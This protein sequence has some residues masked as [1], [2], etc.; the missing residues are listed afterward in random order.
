M[1]S[2]A[3]AHLLFLRARA[4]LALSALVIGCSSGGGTSDTP[5]VVDGGDDASTG[6]T[7]SAPEVGDDA[8][9]A[10]ASDVADT[11][12][13]SDTGPAGCK[14]NADCASDPK[15]KFCLV[16][17]AGPGVCVPCL[18]GSADECPT[19]TYCAS[20]NTCETGCKTAADCTTA[21]SDAGA[22]EAGAD[23]AGDGGGAK[24]TCNTTTHRCV[25]CTDDADCPLGSVCDATSNACVPG[26]NPKH[27]CAPGK[28]CCGTTC[29]DTQK[30]PNNCGGCGKTC[31]TVANGA[32]G[33]AAGECG[34]GKCDLGYDDC[35]KKAANGCEVSLDTSAD[36]C[37]AC[38]NKCSLSN[39]SASCTA[40]ACAIAACDP[41]FDDCDKDPKNGCETSLKTETNCGTCGTVCAIPNATSS[42]STGTCTRVACNA[43][44]DDCDKDPKNGCEANLTTGGAGPS[45]SNTIVN[46]KTCGNTCSVT[47]GTPACG[48]AG[49]EVGSCSGKYDD[50]NKVYADGCETDKSTDKLNCGI[51]GK[52]CNGTNG[53]PS[54]SASACSIS[55]NVGFDN[56]DLD[57]NTGCEVNLTNDKNNCNGCGK[58]CATSSTVTGTKCVPGSIA[59]TGEC[60]VAT[61]AANTFDNDGSFANGC[62]CTGDSHANTCAGATDLGTVDIGATAKTLTANLSGTGG[63]ED[64]F[65]VPCLATTPSCSFKP[66]IAL[67][68]G[69]FVKM[70]VQSSCAGGGINCGAGEP[71]TSATVPTGATGFDT[72]EYTYTAECGEQK[73]IDP[74]D[75]ME[76]FCSSGF[77]KIPTVLYIRVLRN[78]SSTTCYPYTL[79]IT[80]Q[81]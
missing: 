80:N 63:D 64:W 39:A 23:G 73:L 5:S 3:S 6:D 74:T 81:F 72:W 70:L 32:P 17:D 60:G 11:A 55:C 66:K 43:G 53:T 58:V 67:S 29:Y 62:E 4:V 41:G 65:P 15:G 45:G 79:T 31:P 36:H 77:V 48:A 20:T 75:C 16:G 59:G 68:G 10:D 47:N 52:V 51:C 14:T 54:C 27:P 12:P 37:G 57:P 38:F 71:A 49:C 44:F 26:C 25:G 21:G 1:S 50:C 28:E 8:A 40:G 9:G 78:G 46:C 22:D 42:C 61:C 35:D 18:T 56:C 33:C 2:S 69:G 34:V 7:G 13:P 19:G 30:D 76:E 24:L